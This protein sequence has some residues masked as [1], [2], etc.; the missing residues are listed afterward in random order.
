MKEQDT[1]D[2][3]HEKRFSGLDLKINRFHIINPDKGELM[4]QQ[5]KSKG[6]SW[7][8]ITLVFGGLSGFF[9]FLTIHYYFEERTM[10]VFLF[11]GIFVLP[12]FALIALSL[13]DK[14]S[15]KA[16]WHFTELELIVTP[17]YGR[18]KIVPR[19]DVKS[20]YILAKTI[21][22][23]DGGSTTHYSVMLR[24]PNSRYEN[25]AYTL[26]QIEKDDVAKTN[27]GNINL[28][29]ILGPEGES[30]TIAELISGHW[31][32]PLSV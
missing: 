7:I 32:I 27:V 15:D 1:L 5:L 30:R 21:S 16:K 28:Q 14:F 13:Y 11:P 2:Q 20:V 23:S 12:G 8:W 19:A 6:Y 4:I 17:Q 29:S 18:K 25:G 10:M 26:I 3:P 22:Y 24:I 9:L 31:K